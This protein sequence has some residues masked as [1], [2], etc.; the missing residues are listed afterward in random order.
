MHRIL[1]LDK[2]VLFWINGH[3]NAV[4]DAILAPI[5]YAGE[6]GAIWVVIC[7]GML[8]FG[9]ARERKTAVLLLVT[10][11]VVDRLI[12]ANLRLLFDRP[13]PYVALAGIRAIGVH[14]TSGSFPSAHAHSVW[15]AA[16][17]LGSRY[18]RLIW[19]LVAFAILTCYSRPYFGM[20]YPLDTLAGAVL[21]IAA[22]FGA[23][24]IEKLVARR[25]GK[26]EC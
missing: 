7:L 6:A 13:R 8:V 2:H 20:H 19:P 5:A 14:W 1:D 18:R 16:I 4:L 3:H 10:M 22:G 9:R 15:I 25:K 26:G 23:L 12:A 17:I 11:A 21:G 24:G